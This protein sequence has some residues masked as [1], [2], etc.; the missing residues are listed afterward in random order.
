MKRI[1]NKR[2]Q[3]KGIERDSIKGMIKSDSGRLEEKK[4]KN[5]SLV[6]N[7]QTIT[8]VFKLKNKRNHTKTKIIKQAPKL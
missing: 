1:K 3:R 6:K 7:Y 4:R 2:T 5:K 8:F